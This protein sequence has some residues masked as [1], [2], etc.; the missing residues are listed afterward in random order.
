MTIA[1]RRRISWLSEACVDYHW[2]SWILMLARGWWVAHFV[3]QSLHSTEELFVREF[4]VNVSI[5]CLPR[6]VLSYFCQDTNSVQSTFG[7][8]DTESKQWKLFSSIFYVL[9][10]LK[11]S[12]T[13]NIPSMDLT[14]IRIS[15]DDVAN[16]APSCRPISQ[17]KLSLSHSALLSF[18]STVVETTGNIFGCLSL[19][20]DWSQLIADEEDVIC[21]LQFSHNVR[22]TSYVKLITHLV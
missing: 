9:D 11:V 1:R 19:N 15:F 17:H 12:P 2:R 16:L 10:R 13:S 20:Q 3:R 7:S 22:N 4:D 21:N 18:P 6:H 14:L 8:H 5:V